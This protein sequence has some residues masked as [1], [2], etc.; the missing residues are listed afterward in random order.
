MSSYQ[1]HAD[2][3]PEGGVSVERQIKLLDQMR[4]VLR[5]KHMSIR[6]QEAYVSWVRR[7]ILFHGKRHPTDIGAEE[8]RV[9]LTHLA[10]HGKVAAPTRSGA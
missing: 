6:T 5:L 2:T 9:F 8:I 7:F 4:S 3:D 1:S 10:V